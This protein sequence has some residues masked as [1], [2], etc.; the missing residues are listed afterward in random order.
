MYWHRCEGEP[1]NLVTFLSWWVVF[2]CPTF[3]FNLKHWDSN[4]RRPSFLNPLQGPWTQ[5]ISWVMLR[6]C[7]SWCNWSIYVN[8]QICCLNNRSS[9][10]ARD[11]SRDC[12]D[13]WVGTAQLT[14]S[15]KET[16]GVGLLTK[17][18]QSRSLY[19]EYPGT[20]MPWHSGPGIHHSLAHDDT[21]VGCAHLYAKNHNPRSH[22]YE[23]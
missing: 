19:F 18:W 2:N 22:C 7:W 10:K 12:V 1:I 20:S 13:W 17:E 8:I 6:L 4:I 16:E 21:T 3:I 9:F 15:E 23:E 5:R 11:E 14:Y